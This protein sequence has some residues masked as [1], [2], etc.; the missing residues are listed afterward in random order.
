ME[1]ECRKVKDSTQILRDRT[2]LAV[3]THTGTGGLWP[4]QQISTLH[5]PENNK[6]QIIHDSIVHGR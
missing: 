3:G 6:K 4:S 2:C 5:S 1:H